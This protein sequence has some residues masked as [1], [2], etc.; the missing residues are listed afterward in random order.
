[1]NTTLRIGICTLDRLQVRLHGTYTA[2]GRSYTG[3][4]T[5]SQPLLLEPADADCFFELQHVTIGVQF[6][7]Q[8][9][10]TQRF[11]GALECKS[12]GQGHWIAVNLISLEDYIYSVIS[13]EMNAHAHPELLKAHAVISR[14]WAMFQVTHPSHPAPRTDER[15]DRIIRW[16]EHDSHTLFDLCADDH[17]QRYQ[18]IGRIDTPAVAEAIKATR[19]EMLTYQG[20]ICDARFYKSCG[21]VTELFSTCWAPVNPPYLKS[22][23]DNPA[24]NTFDLTREEDVR[25]FILSEPTAYCNT[26]DAKILTQVLNRYDQSTTDFFRWEVRYTPRQLHDLLQRKSGIDFG[27]IR[28]LTALKRGPSGRIEELRI[29]GSRRTVVVGKELEIRK[30][31]SESHLYSSCLIVDRTADGGFLLRG[32]GWGHGVG[33]CQIG[34]AVMATQGFGYR[35]IL[36]HYYPGAEITAYV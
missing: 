18:G 20:D 12:D 30:W 25:A 17:C 24:G 1:M 16:Y 8:Q 28:Q 35:E 23:A 6:H 9:E 32:A 7:W 15:A 33:L 13:S 27:E 36:A 11:R 26:R 2:Q 14:S 19:G 3:D 29:E 22:I 21:G 5:L 31:L 4:M 10:E 34:A